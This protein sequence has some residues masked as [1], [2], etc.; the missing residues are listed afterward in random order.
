[1]RTGS[2]IDLKVTKALHLAPRILRSRIELTIRQ[3]D[4]GDEQI[5]TD[6]NLRLAMETE[7]LR[8]DPMLV[9]AGVSALLAD[10]AKGIYFLAESDET[11]A[12]QL[13]ITYEWSDWRNGNLWWI[14]S[15]YV[16]QEFRRMGVFRRLFRYLENLARERPDVR[17]L[18]LYMHV[19][20]LSARRTYEKL[21]MHQTK[22]EVFELE[23]DPSAST[24]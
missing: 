4:L 18:R 20:N 1:M 5:I 11:I 21:G 15:V 10:S 17:S 7:G 9:K 6:F 12:G 8:L 24:E 3:A 23:L 22:Y 2:S 14:Q 16:R 13:M 19:D